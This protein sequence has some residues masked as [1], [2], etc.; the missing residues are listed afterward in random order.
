M[1]HGVVHNHASRRDTRHHLLLHLLLAREHVRR[2]R[3]IS[4][5]DDVNGLLHTLHLH[6]REGKVSQERG[7]NPMGQHPHGGGIYLTFL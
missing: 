6:T 7:G 2:Q 3:L 1:H 4:I 5:I